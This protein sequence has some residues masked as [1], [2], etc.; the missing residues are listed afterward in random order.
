M[1]FSEGAMQGKFEMVLKDVTKRQLQKQFFVAF[2]SLSKYL[3]FGRETCPPT[4]RV[5]EF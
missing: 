1:Q 4:H 3:S 5:P 2:H